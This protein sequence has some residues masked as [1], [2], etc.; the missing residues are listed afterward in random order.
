MWHEGP[1]NVDLLRRLR[2]AVGGGGRVLVFLGAGVSFGA[3]R[4]AGRATFGNEKYKP[5]P[6][7]DYPPFEWSSN[8]DDLPLPSWSDRHLGGTVPSA[9]RREASPAP[10]ETPWIDRPDRLDR[11]YAERLCARPHRAQGDAQSLTQ[12]D[13]RWERVVMERG[14]ARLAGRPA[15]DSARSCGCDRAPRPEAGRGAFCPRPVTAYEASRD[16]Q[17]S[18]RLPRSSQ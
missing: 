7:H 15:Q 10:R 1:G 13:G 4:V 9:P 12:R 11:P 16:P 5:W 14:E 18:I 3:A 17:P 8:D 2:A 6:P